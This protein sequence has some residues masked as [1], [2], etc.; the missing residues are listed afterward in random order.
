MKAI[1]YIFIVISLLS[2]SNNSDYK[3]E[4]DPKALQSWEVRGKDTINRT[5]FAK[6][7]QGRWE[8]SKAVTNESNQT[9]W[10]LLEEGNYV[11]NKKE[12]LWKTYHP[13]GKLKDSLVYK[14]DV[15]VK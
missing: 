4:R 7:K 13:D 1:L 2:C 3:R 12:G 5:D 14:N 11:D 8:I 9:T 10:I 15:V 6:N